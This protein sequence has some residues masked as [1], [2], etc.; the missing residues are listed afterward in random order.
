MLATRSGSHTLYFASALGI[1]SMSQPAADFTV[2]QIVHIDETGDSYYRMRW[3]ARDLAA[4]CPS[5]RVINLDA[6]ASERHEWGREADLLIVYQSH[7][8]SLLPI[9]AQRRARGLHTLV[10]YNDN[11]YA[12]PAA[13]PVAK[14]W[15]SPLVRQMYEIF[16]RESDGVIVTGPGLRDLLAAHVSRPLHILENHLPAKPPIFR[17]KRAGEIA[18]SVGWAGSL[19]HMEDLLAVAP[20]LQQLVRET[21]GLN[22]HL[23]GNETIP[24]LMGIPAERLRFRPW[25]TM[26]QYFAFWDEVE[27]GLAPQLASAYNSCRS[28][29]KAVEM[30]SRG[31]L[32][33]LTAGP[34]YNDF[35]AAT[36]CPAFN[37]LSGLT[38]LLK[39]FIADPNAREETAR[40]CHEYVA[41]QR[42]G[43]E[44]RERYELY[45]QHLPDRPQS[46]AWP[47]A[48]GY[49]EH[50]GTPDPG[51]YLENVKARLKQ[52]DELR[53][54][55]RH[56]EVRRELD[57]L[58]AANL[59]D[60][61][62]ALAWI[63]FGFEGDRAKQAAALEGLEAAFP[64]DLRFAICRAVTAA[65]DPLAAWARVVDLTEKLDD[66]ERQFMTIE[67]TRRMSAALL[68]DQRL[69]PQVERLLKLIPRA[70]ALRLTCAE[71]A[72]QVGEYARAREHF[73]ILIHE[74]AIAQSGPGFWSELSDGYL[75]SMH[76]AMAAA[77]SGKLTVQPPSTEF[78]DHL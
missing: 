75:S 10:E 43:V 47:L 11:F 49:H 73:A 67:L 72:R 57:A 68:Q 52:V 61:D 35:I 69:L 64:R 39:R 5:W 46:Y 55:K 54:A 77:A 53:R 8:V 27:I 58:R 20:M 15:S 44:H 13:S 50:R 25:G 1:I 24:G 31:V 18:K 3:P 9:M 59:H 2:V 33:L 6:R 51:R 71:V 26:D 37:D 14:E 4:Q 28:D 56:Q 65:T 45:R 17:A 70:A 74:R 34:A 60:P 78:K 12:P 42:I 32:P 16:M 29:I 76:A 21:P 63:Y 22:I 30:S 7:D 48:P 40:R 38:D 62:V 66:A 19:G 41:S 36:A 23:M